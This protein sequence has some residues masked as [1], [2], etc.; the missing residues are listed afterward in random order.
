MTR[1]DEKRAS[2]L[3]DLDLRLLDA[4][5]QLG[6]EKFADLEILTEDANRHVLTQA[7]RM[8]YERGYTAA[9]REDMQGDRA[10]LFLDHRYQPP[11]GIL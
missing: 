1:E 5:E 6:S 11:E 8:A 7:M 10:K 2:F 3:L 4:W 9:L